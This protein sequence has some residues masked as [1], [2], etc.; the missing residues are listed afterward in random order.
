[1]KSAAE[2]RSE[3]NPPP[4]V[5]RELS[6]ESSSANEI[7]YLEQRN[8]LI[9]LTKAVPADG[10]DVLGAFRRITETTA[11]TLDVSRVSI[12]KYSP[13]LQAIECLDLYE[14]DGNRHTSGGTLLAADFPSYFSGLAEMELIAADDARTDPH[15][16]EFFAN[17]LVPLGITSMMDV[18][19]R[20]QNELSYLLCNEHIGP[21]RLWT[22]DE[23]T[24]A[25]AIANLISLA[26]ESSGRAIAQQE[27]L[28]SHQRFESVAAATNDTIWDWNL[29]SDTF[30]WN[31]GFANLFGWAASGAGASIQA[32]IR[33]IHPED[34]ARVVS[35]IYRAIHEGGVHW[36]D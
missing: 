15:T 10:I 12:W 32:W 14:I 11:V 2:E 25:V 5:G 23:K 13:G 29:E 22:P 33:Q 16:S 35:G 19:I 28:R 20:S 24:F 26:L 30:W 17:Y 34:C 4:A 9:T 7:R 3:G 31:D 6:A 1:M 27:V 21:A 36:T 18:P 8:A